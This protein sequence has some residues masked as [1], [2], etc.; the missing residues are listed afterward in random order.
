VYSALVLLSV[1]LAVSGFFLFRFHSQV[2]TFRV[3]FRDN[4]SAEDELKQSQA[5]LARMRQEAESV[6][7]SI[8]KQRE[9]AA[10]DLAHSKD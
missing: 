9:D 8:E 6:A 1:A 10:K 5:A 7:R 2:L 4:L 3:R